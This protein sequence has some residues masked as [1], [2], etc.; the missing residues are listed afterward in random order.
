MISFWPPW[1][2]GF[3][4]SL[5]YYYLPLG[6]VIYILGE[7]GLLQDTCIIYVWLIFALRW[8]RSFGLTFLSYWLNH[9]SQECSHCNKTFHVPVCFS[10]VTNA[11]VVKC[12]FSVIKYGIMNVIYWATS[13]RCCS[14]APLKLKPSRSL[15]VWI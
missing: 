14:V 1:L 13:T 5:L 9:F 2:E 3:I 15:F 11:I 4:S 7:C 12:E 8:M 6:C 10:A